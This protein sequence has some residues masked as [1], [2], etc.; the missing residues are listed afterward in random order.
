MRH[1]SVQCVVRAGLIGKDIGNDA[2]LHDFRQD[3]GAISDESD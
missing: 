3:I 2:A 1:V